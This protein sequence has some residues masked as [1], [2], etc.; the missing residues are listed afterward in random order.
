MSAEPTFCLYCGKTNIEDAGTVFIEDGP[1]NGSRYANEGQFQRLVCRDCGQH[2]GDMP[3]RVKCTKCGATV[4]GELG[5][6]CDQDGEHE[7]GY[8]CVECMK[9]GGPEE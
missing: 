9:H 4:S 3:E 8:L 5:E 1:Y 6:D 7:D 2:F